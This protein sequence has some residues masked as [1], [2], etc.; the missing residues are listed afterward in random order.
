VR[1]VR[2]GLNALDFGEAGL[3]GA[4]HQIFNDQHRSARARDLSEFSTAKPEI[5]NVDLLAGLA[6]KSEMRARCGPAPA[7]A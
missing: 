6:Q 1:P 3:S 5:M 7:L 2:I 4:F